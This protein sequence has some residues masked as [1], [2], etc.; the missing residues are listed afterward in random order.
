VHHT[1][2]GSIGHLCNEEITAL[3]QQELAK[4]GFEKVENAQQQL[5]QV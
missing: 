3:M 4:F 5:L 1:H 2:E